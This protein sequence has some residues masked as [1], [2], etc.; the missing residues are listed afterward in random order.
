MQTITYYCDLCNAKIIY[1]RKRLLQI[2]DIAD[3]DDDEDTMEQII[4]SDSYDL[5]PSCA[6]ALKDWIDNRGMSE[7]GFERDAYLLDEV[8]LPYLVDNGG[9]TL[10]EAYQSG[11]LAL[12]SGANS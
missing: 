12:G 1:G 3:D 9:T 2:A 10:F 5:C 8:F 7:C 4:H 6:K 11:R